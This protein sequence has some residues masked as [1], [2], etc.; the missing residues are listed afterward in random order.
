MSGAVKLMRYSGIIC[1]F[2]KALQMTYLVGE[3]RLSTPESNSLE[4]GKFCLE[5]GL[6]SSI[7]PNITRHSTICFNPVSSV[8]EQNALKKKNIL[9]NN[10]I[11]KTT[12]IFFFTYA[13]SEKF[14]TK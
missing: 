8:I 14:A 3:M 5:P 10:H 4:L 11:R 7:L 1:V 6:S 9:I 2:I 12:I 13:S